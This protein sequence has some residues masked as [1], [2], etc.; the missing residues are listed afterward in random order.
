MLGMF[1]KTSL[2][3]VGHAKKEG[4]KPVNCKLTFHKTVLHCYNLTL[5]T[6][7]KKCHIST[8]HRIT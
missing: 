3:L 7:T 8:Y 6:K 5:A 2:I 1:A 4:K